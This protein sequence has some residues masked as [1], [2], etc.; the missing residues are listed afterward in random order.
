[1]KTKE[2]VLKGFVDYLNGC[3]L[4]KTTV[5]RSYYLVGRFLAWLKGCDIREVSE[6]KI[7]E[8]REYLST[9]V[10][11]FTRKPL[12]RASLGVEMS[13]VKSFFEYLFRHE[14]ILK[15]PLEGI[16][17]SE[18]GEK[19]LR[20][21]FSE[22]EISR[23]LDSIPV[24]GPATQRDRTV[25][26]L[27]YSSGLRV[28]EA[29][30][31]EFEHLNLDERVVLIKMG[32]G[33]KDRYVPFS[34][35]ALRCLLSYIENGRKIHLQLIKRLEDKRYVFLGGKG[36]VGYRR[37]RRRFQDYLEACGL[38][39]RGYTMHSMRHAAATHLL[40]H[41]ASIRYVQELLG[42]EDLKTTQLYTRPQVENIKRVYRT[43]HPRE[44]EYFKEVDEEYL[45]HLRE[46]RDEL[47]KKRF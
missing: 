34:V 13:A 27:M 11:R 21:I 4:S 43:Y 2:V 41:G 33:K 32:K 16:R 8:Y 36:K 47:L 24:T 39:E 20:K 7:G 14:L 10:S 22:A 23:F 15:N 9:M 35:A 29:L 28:N 46:L 25:F 38:K 31:I 12:K 42:H 30:N 18:H 3:G 37:M 45:R 1:M 5:E 6:K 40:Q 26:E 44:N 17:F 19:S